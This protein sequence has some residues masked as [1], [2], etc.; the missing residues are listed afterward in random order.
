MDELLFKNRNKEYGAYKLRKQYN[1]T[2]AI[3]LAVSIV[4]VAASVLIPF[5]LNIKEQY[6]EDFVI[7][8]NIVAVELMPLEELKKAEL[9]PQQKTE[10][11]KIENK[12]EEKTEVLKDSIHEK[13]L[14]DSLLLAEKIKKEK[15]EEEEIAKS[16]GIFS[17]GDGQ[18]FSKWVDENF[19]RDLLR[20]NKQKGTILLKFSV[21]EKGIVDSAN[22]LQGLNPV[23]DNEAKRV[24]LSSPRWKPFIFNGHR[25]RIEC[26]LPIYIAAY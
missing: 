25:R 11:P 5:L 10:A 3:S 22:I 12:P 17:I 15:E 24:I 16:K 6:S 18:V 9:K 23:L 13:N 14:K 4:I 2:L 21:N 8:T 26:T 1:K 19:N 7:R 20:N